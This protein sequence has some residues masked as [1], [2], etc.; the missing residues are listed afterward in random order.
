[1]NKIK[2]LLFFMTVLL[3]SCGSQQE[4]K[5]MRQTIS[6]LETVLFSD[7]LGPV[8]RLKAQEMIQAYDDFV[9]LFPEDS[10]AP[11]YLYKGSELAM[12]LQMSGHAIEGFQEILNNYPDFDKIALCVFLQAFIYENQMQQYDEAKALY[13]SFIEKYPSHE[14]AED[15]LVSMQ[16]MGK[17]LEDL[18]KS[19]EESE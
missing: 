16:N 3:V 1:M 19:W 12:N 18:I 10:L 5:Q 8:D 11:E 14:L 7:T 13:R 15:A 4:K 17:S 9:K 2:L 6:S